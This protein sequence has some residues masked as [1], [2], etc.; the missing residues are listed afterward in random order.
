MERTAKPKNVISEEER[1]MRKEYTRLRDI[2]RKRLQRLENSDFS[3]SNI[4]NKWKG[5]IPKLSE[6]KDPSDLA[7]AFRE[8]SSLIKSPLS[9]IK[10]QRKAM[11]ST[12]DTINTLERHFPGLD[13]STPK[14]FTDFTRAM[15]AQV[16][17][18]LESIFGSDRM[19]KLFKVAKQKGIKNINPL[20]KDPKAM[21]YWLGNVS[22]LE[23]VNLPEGQYKSAKA[24]REA[25]NNMIWHGIDYDDS[26]KSNISNYDDI[27][28]GK[29]K[30]AGYR[31]RN[32]KRGRNG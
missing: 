8:L 31:S 9:T 10:G 13:I 28:S 14:K 29:K 12:Q 1:A 21:A 16:Y 26:T 4:L 20:L 19:V 25:I 24:Y 15:N 27:V 22:N 2:G 7:L 18:N 30:P 5:G 32:R 11:K 3:E 17:N 23:S 6:L